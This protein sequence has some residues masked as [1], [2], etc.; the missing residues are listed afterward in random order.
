MIHVALS[1]DD[2]PAFRYKFIYWHMSR[3]THLLSGPEAQ[4]A[5]QH[6]MEGEY[7][8]ADLIFTKLN[9]RLDRQYGVQTESRPA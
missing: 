3:E 9:G 4:E 5:L 6:A 1:E 8:M 7:A 2:S